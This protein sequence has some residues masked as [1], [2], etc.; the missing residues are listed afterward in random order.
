M[1]VC[2]GVLGLMMLI[3]CSNPTEKNVKEINVGY[4]DNV[5]VF[6]NFE[7]KKDYDVRMEKEIGSEVKKLDSLNLELKKCLPGDS[8]RYYALSKEYYVFEQKYNEI[9][10]GLS[11][12]Y[13]NE[14]N[15]RLNEY[16]KLFSEQ[17]GY[18]LLIGSSGQGNVMYVDSI[19]NVTDD[20]VQFIN[21]EYA[22]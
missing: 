19:V 18:N 16:I 12:K 4:I 2:I 11:T 22:N 17:K 10:Q 1:K 20:L 15:T 9:F 7:M 13:T 21:T 6:E 14:V 5:R 3:G 8:L